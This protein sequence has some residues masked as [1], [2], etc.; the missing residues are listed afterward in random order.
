MKENEY[1]LCLD[2]R[3]FNHSLEALAVA[4]KKAGAINL[5]VGGKYGFG[6]T[7][8]LLENWLHPEV[9]LCGLQPEVTH[10]FLNNIRERIGNG[11]FFAADQTYLDITIGYPAIFRK[12]NPVNF[13]EFTGLGFRYYKEYKS[14]LG[15]AYSVLQ[16][17]W[18]DA[19]KRFPWDAGYSFNAEIQP[20]LYL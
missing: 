17:F 15:S 6:Y 10:I 2:G 19:E 4:V 12:V 13:G 3:D 16:M 7:I 9:I 8:G 18:S 20:L 5:I 14:D 1:Q 11:E